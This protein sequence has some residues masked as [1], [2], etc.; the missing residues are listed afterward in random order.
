M[1]R[2]NLILAI[3]FG[4]FTSNYSQELSKL[5]ASEVPEKVKASFK[6]DYPYAKNVLW[7]K[8]GNNFEAEY[9]ENRAVLISPEGVILADKNDILP[10]NLPE[11]IL[12]F[13]RDNENNEKV[14]KSQRVIYTDGTVSFLVLTKKF[15]YKFDTKA[16]LLSKDPI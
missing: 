9:H 4:V 6:S 11:A 15:M 3:V 13:M 1:N 12:N 14:T 7:E 8:N 2:F 16:K 10:K 5:K